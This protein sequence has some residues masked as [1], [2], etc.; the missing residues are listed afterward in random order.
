MAA[1]LAPL[2]ARPS[3]PTCFRCSN[4][5]TRSRRRRCPR[6]RPATILTN[7]AAGCSPPCASCWSRCARSRPLVVCI[8]DLHWTDDDSLRLLRD[9]LRPPMTPRL[10]L[11]VTVRTAPEALTGHVTPEELIARSGAGATVLSLEKL[12]PAEQRALV[13]RRRAT[14]RRPSDNWRGEHPRRSRRAPAVH[15]RAGAA[16]C[17]ERLAGRCALDDA[18]CAHIVRLEQPA[19]ALLEL[20]SIAGGPVTQAAALRRRRLRARGARLVQPRRWSQERLALTRAE[21]PTDTIEPYHDRVRETVVA[22]LDARGARRAATASWRSPS[23]SSSGEADP[24]AARRCTGAAPASA[25]AHGRYLSPR[26]RRG[27]SRCSRSIAPR[28][29]TSSARAPQA[30]AAR[31]RAASA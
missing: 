30:P 19:Q 28:A 15:R 14:F 10:L 9:F 5:A 27:A 1:S 12:P 7:G 23:R 26:R 20:V 18:L 13:V 22:R 21:R 31:M 11:I 16:P 17:F 24:G 29:S 25:S 3:S 4:S 8:D 6:C 2:D